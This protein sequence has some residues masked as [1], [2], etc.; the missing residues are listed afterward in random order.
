MLAWDF[1]AVKQLST[2]R[3]TSASLAP[4]LLPFFSS[5]Q[6]LLIGGFAAVIL[7]GA[8]LLKLPWSQF[9]AVSFLDCLFTST[10]A[11][12]VTGLVVVDTGT[13]YTTWGQVVILFLIQTGGLGVMTFAALTFQMLGRRLS[14]QSQAVLHDSFFQQDIGGEFKH[15]FVRIL[16][17]TALIEAVGA[18]LIF[19]GLWW[20]TQ[21]IGDSLYSAVFHSISAF[22]NAG[23]SI[24][25]DNLIEMR[26]NYLIVFTI[27]GL[28]FVG[29]LGYAVLLE[30]WRGLS[31]RWQGN[32]KNL[33]LRFS[34]HTRVVLRVSTM[35]IIGGALVLLV[36]GL[37]RGEV[38]AGERL[39]A[40]LFQSVTAR[41]AG[42]N[43]IDIGKLPLNSILLIALLMFIGGSPG[44]C[45]GGIK[46]TSFAIFMAEMRS[47]LRGDPDVRL[48]DRRVPTQT[49]WR[50]TILI[51]LALAWNIA[52]IFLLLTTE[53]SNPGIGM[54]DVV[55]EQISAF[56]TV[57][58]STGI[59][60]KLTPVGKLWIIL[61][62]FF[63]RVG[64]LTIAMWVLPEKHS[65]I[66]YPRAK[67]MIG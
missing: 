9:S 52:G 33:A 43:T 12:C 31:R 4:R 24:Y 35:L 63:G 22:C 1:S 28:I 13:A 55:F 67:V 51:R 11:V 19:L 3:A 18:A 65:L 46:T 6:F 15:Q 25:K 27:M 32:P 17:T 38:S 66:R 30:L 5:P 53:L 20:R 7:T 60:D 16:F 23:F 54:H 41:T 57:G 47:K 64:P 49:L 44:S 45:A 50:T 34:T 62:M 14:L 39:S 29:G 59:T 36:F 26:S 2:L 48:L 42:F 10:S 58:L 37:T 61:T 40:A 8:I 21:R 56:G